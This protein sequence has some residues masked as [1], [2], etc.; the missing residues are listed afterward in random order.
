MVVFEGEVDL[1]L[2]DSEFIE[3]GWIRRKLKLIDGQLVE[4][5]RGSAMFRDDSSG[6]IRGTKTGKLYNKYEVLGK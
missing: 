2:E 4:V 3:E 1:M 6:L 5:D